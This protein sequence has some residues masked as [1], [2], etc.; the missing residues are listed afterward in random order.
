MDL[1]LEQLKAEFSKNFQLD[2]VPEEKREALMEK[3]GEVLLK[4]IF[5]ETMEKIG[6]DG[7]AGYEKLLEA[8]A[9]EEEIGE[10]FESQIP[11][12]Q[13][14]VREVIERFQEDMRAKMAE[15]SA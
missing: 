14:F 6:P 4:N 1:S 3:M 8:E 9:S 15:L 7:V 13:V 10:F 12:Y 2:G 11:G 5:V